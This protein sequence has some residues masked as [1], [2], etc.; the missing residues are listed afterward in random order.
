[1]TT[2][3]TFWMTKTADADLAAAIPEFRT[4]LP[5][6]WFTIGDCSV[7]SHASCGPDRNHIPQPMLSKFDSGFHE[8]LDQPATM[9]QALRSVNLQALEAIREHERGCP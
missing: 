7:S 1:M 3:Q 5:G 2:A 8:D 4:S 6:W 9:A